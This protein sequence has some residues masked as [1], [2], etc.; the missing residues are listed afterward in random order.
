[1][2]E[3]P[4]PPPGG[5][6]IIY[7]DPPWQFKT[8]AP[9]RANSRAP[10]YPTLS[11]PEIRALPVA[12]AA[13]SNSLLAMWVYDPMLPEAIRLAEVW[14]FKY[15]TVLF[16]WLKG[17]G[18]LR[19]FEDGE[20]L[21]MALG[22][23]TRGGGCEE[24]WLFR[25]GRGLPVLRHDIRKEFYSPRREHSRKPDEVRGWLVD[26]YGD[27]PRLEMFARTSTPGWSVFGNETSKFE[28]AE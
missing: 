24:C 7:S 15:V 10:K 18:R 21:P 8:Y 19:L 22:Y 17:D 12:D 3:L 6:R 9:A 4:P 23:H 5:Y 13:A 20:K 25:R 16:R 1:M 26:L 11:L 28:A 27:Y 2:G 14:G